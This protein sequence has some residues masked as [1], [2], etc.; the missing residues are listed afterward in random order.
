M[1]LLKWLSVEL[2]FLF[3]AGNHIWIVSLPVNLSV[4]CWQ[5][6]YM[7][8]TALDYMVEANAQ[9]SEHGESFSEIVK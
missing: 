3:T 7:Y 2:S 6:I 4:P 8:D 9:V 1:E 5:I